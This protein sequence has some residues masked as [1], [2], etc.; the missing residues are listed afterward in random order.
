M[1]TPNLPQ[2]LIRIAIAVALPTVACFGFYSVDYLDEKNSAL[3]LPTI[4]AYPVALIGLIGLA[5]ALL[6]PPP[7]RNNIVMWA[8]V[9]LIPITFILF[10]RS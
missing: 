7:S 10:V 8:L 1:T 9:I 5:R 3:I 6:S 4:L 2:W